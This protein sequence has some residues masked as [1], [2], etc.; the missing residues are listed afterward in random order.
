MIH[1]STSQNYLENVFDTPRKWYFLL[2]KFSV[3]LTI[4]I[5]NS[6]WNVAKILCLFSPLNSA[7]SIIWDMRECG[8]YLKHNKVFFWC[9]DKRQSW[10]GGVQTAPQCFWRLAERCWHSSDTECLRRLL[11]QIVKFRNTQNVSQNHHNGKSNRF[12]ILIV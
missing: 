6:F 4:I 10:T 9:Q 7:A 11:K 8:M 5:R 2:K 12:L 3:M 1:P